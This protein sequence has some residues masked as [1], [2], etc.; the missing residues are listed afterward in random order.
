MQLLDYQ[1]DECESLFHEK[2][3]RALRLLFG[4]ALPDPVKHASPPSGFRLRTEFRVWHDGDALHYVMFPP[5]DSLNPRVIDDFPIAGPR[6]TEAMAP[7]RAM[8]QRSTELRRKLFQVEFLSTLSG[9]LLVTLIYHRP[10][11]ESWRA[12]ALKLTD[13]LSCK[14]IGRSRKQKLVLET[15]WVE[16]M[17]EVDGQHYRYRQPEQCFTQ[18]NGII[19]QQMMTWLLTQCATIDTDLLELYCGI[20]NFTLPLS[21]R[22]RNVLATELSKPATAAARWNA[23][24]NTTSNIELARLSAQEMT[25]AMA[26]ERPF[27][28]L[29]HLK[30]ALKQY[31]FE[32]LLVDPPRAGLDEATRALAGNFT[33]VLYISCSPETLARDLA[34]LSATHEIESLAFFDQF[35]YTHHLE[36][37][38]VLKKKAV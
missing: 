6:I 34:T 12:Q 16:E 2:T 10:L 18:P 1:P 24:H 9:Q 4:L 8:L 11:D 3:E 13:A 22:F 17:I 36:S 38:V 29:A 5:G 32:T 7:L 35:P 25:A 20:G 15:D 31:Q 37:G 21:Q 27:Q 23:E 26:G 14:I 30:Q 33:R 19:N 28:R